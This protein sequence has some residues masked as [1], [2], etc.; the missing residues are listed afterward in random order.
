V[1][2]AGDFLTLFHCDPREISS[3]GYHWVRDYD[4][5]LL[6]GGDGKLYGSGSTAAPDF[7]DEHAFIFRFSIPSNTLPKLSI[8]RSAEAM[9][10]PGR[11]PSATRFWNKPTLCQR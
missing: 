10:S 2:P 8:A 4:N 9:V 3:L 6:Q 5:S 1:T 11:Q 7:H